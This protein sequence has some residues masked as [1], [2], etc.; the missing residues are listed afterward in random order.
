MCQIFKPEIQNHSIQWCWTTLTG[1]DAEDFLQR[2][3]TVNMNSLSVGKGSPGCFLNSQGKF[4]A[5][6]TLWNFGQGEFAFEFN[7]GKSGKW[8][9]E[10]HSFFDQYTFGEKIEL[11]DLTPKMDH[12]WLFLENLD[13]ERYPWLKNLT[14]EHTSIVVEPGIRVS[15][16]GIK[17]Y[18]RFWITGWGESEKLKKW[19]EEQLKDAEELTFEVLE[20][21]RIQAARP[22]MGSEINENTTP[23]DVGL[24]DS[25]SQ[26]KGC[27]PG[28]EVIERIIAL[29]SPP[30]RL[31][32][33]DGTGD[34]PTPG[35][36]VLN[37]AQPPI[38]VGEVTSSIARSPREFSALALVKKIHTK[39]G[40]RV[41]FS[42]AL[43]SHGA[44]LK[45]APYA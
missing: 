24:I 30:K 14:S 7:A 4:R 11:L 27:Y 5:F 33:I 6:F 22:Q 34:V 43:S 3:S 29:G 1:P 20:G 39:E 15:N 40:L 37:Q 23:L 2:L 21:W 35:E 16:H 36:L 32:R 8:R 19:Q 31:V 12:F 18:G 13:L 41:Q 17:D 44:I 10:L 38:E 25:I 26:Q 45:I 28:Q 9:N 42:K